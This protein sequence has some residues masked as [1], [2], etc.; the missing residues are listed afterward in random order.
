MTTFLFYI[1][2]KTKYDQMD[3]PHLKGRHENG[4]LLHTCKVYCD[5]YVRTD[6]QWMFH[7]SY[8]DDVVASPTFWVHAGHV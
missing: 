8:T 3:D 2:L 4:P 7:F 1:T 6:P 5:I